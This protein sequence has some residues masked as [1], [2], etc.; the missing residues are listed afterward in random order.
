MKIQVETDRNVAGN[1]ALLLF[2]EGKVRSA[3]E[4]FQD[5]LTRVEVHLGDENGEKAGSSADKRCML[6]ARAIGMQPVVVTEFANSIGD[7]VG[8]ATR[9]MQ[10]LLT[11]A[12]GRIDGRDADATIRQ[13]EAT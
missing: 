10:S 2:V 6:E 4:R 11:S 3:L 9:K 12:F 5:R 7:A 13:N 1:E 8:G